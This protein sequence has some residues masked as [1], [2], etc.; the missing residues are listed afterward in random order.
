[1]SV[2]KISPKVLAR[3]ASAADVAEMSAW[4][5]SDVLAIAESALA[6]FVAEA[7]AA[8]VCNCVIDSLRAADG[9]PHYTT[10][11]NG[12]RVAVYVLMLSSPASSA[13]LTSKQLAWAEAHPESDVWA[14]PCVVQHLKKELAR[15]VVDSVYVLRA[16][17][18][19]SS[20]PETRQFMPTSQRVPH[21]LGGAAILKEHHL[22]RE[23]ANSGTRIY[24]YIAGV[25]SHRHLPQNHE[26]RCSGSGGFPLMLVQTRGSQNGALRVVRAGIYSAENPVNELEIY[27]TGQDSVELMDSRGHVYYAACAELSM[28]P[29]RLKVGMHL[30]WAVNVFADTLVFSENA[31]IQ[32]ESD[33]THVKAFSTRV[34]S[35]RPVDFCGLTGYCLQVP[36]HEKQPD[37]LF[38]IYVFEHL[39]SGR[40]PRVGDAIKVSGKL[41]AAPDSLVETSTCWADSPETT[42]ASHEDELEALALQEK[43]ALL[44]YSAPLA[45]LAASFVK[46]GYRIKEAF[47]PLFRFGR[48]EFRLESPQGS[49]L[50]V[51]VDYVVNQH[52]DKQG[53][54]CR[55]KPDKYPA[56]MAQT[57]QED[58]P[59]DI[60]FVTL[61]LSAV[62]DSDYAVK[63]ELHGAA[64]ELLLPELITVCPEG[65]LTQQDAARL[66][67]DCMATQSFEQLLSVLREDV[68]YCS[69]T[70]GLEYH[71]KMDLLRHLRSC[72]DTW[73]KHNVLKE[74]AFTVRKLEYQGKACYACVASQAGEPVS[75]TIVKVKTSQVAEILALAPVHFKAL[76]SAV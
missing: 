20:T 6:A 18:R 29:E 4:K 22:V 21:C 47:L 68:H 37:L 69:E 28:F 64:P 73:K 63:P 66:F 27:T 9:S 14:V 32:F 33:K 30:R 50:F 60:C 5:E 7:S 48:P 74:I 8:T 34:Q 42:T 2:L 44:P 51:M 13:S 75:V 19:W 53:Y 39:L 26:L 55:F 70:A 58:G 25:A 15:C 12:A 46:A 45:E 61:H 23:V 54:R 72:F 56:H 1:M 52:E 65:T 57:P 10:E 35:V 38:N 62:S 11:L 17:G 49:L 43:T 76:Q 40:V 24:P 3:A 71:S 41:Q 59:A 31:N 67:A 16:R 36:V